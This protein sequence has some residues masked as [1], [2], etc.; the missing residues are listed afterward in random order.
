MLSKQAHFDVPDNGNTEF[1]IN[2]QHNKHLDKAYGGYCVFAEVNND[3][4]MQVCQAIA[5]AI[6]QG[7]KPKITSMTIIESETAS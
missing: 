6:P 7:A 5:K 1:F 3:A 2:L 4:S